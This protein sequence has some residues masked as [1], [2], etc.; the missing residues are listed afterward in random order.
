MLEIQVTSWL[1]N[2]SSIQT[3]T[4]VHAA[5]TSLS[6]GT[7]PLLKEVLAE[8]GRRSECVSHSECI[9]CEL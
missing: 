1:C 2:E 3:V 6:L 4:L 9:Y 7:V 8:V 5:V